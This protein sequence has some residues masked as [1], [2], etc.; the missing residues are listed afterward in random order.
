MAWK[1][2]T[3]CYRT[4]DGVRWPNLC[5]M[6]D[7]DQIERVAS[8]KRQGVRVR[9]RKHFCGYGQ[10]FIHPEDLSALAAE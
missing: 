10:A 7:P 1:L 5:D 6:L 4:F 8:L 3:D 9:I 2:Q